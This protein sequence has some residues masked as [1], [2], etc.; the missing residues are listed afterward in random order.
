MYFKRILYSLL[1]L[2]SIGLPQKQVLASSLY[3]TA[4]GWVFGISENNIGKYNAA[5]E[6]IYTCISPYT[7]NVLTPISG[8]TEFAIAFEVV[9]LSEAVIGIT[10]TGV[11]NPDNQTGADGEQLSCSGK[12]ETTTQ[13]YED[14][15][16]KRYLGHFFGCIR[17]DVFQPVKKFKSRL[18]E[19]AEKVRKEPKK[20]EESLN[21]VPGDPEKK[22]ME[23]R[24]KNGIPVN[25][26]DLNKINKLF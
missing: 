14:I 6:K 1:V 18:Q 9:S 12:Y 25:I 10:D 16:Q 24:L 13:M 23:I 3:F 15:T 22:C 19:L 26:K 20:D 5:Q 11:F 4:P 8:Q 21:M 17:V 2:C 7:N